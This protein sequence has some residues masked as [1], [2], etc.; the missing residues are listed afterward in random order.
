MKNSN[1]LI[2]LTDYRHSLYSTVKYGNASDNGIDLNRLENHIGSHGFKIRILNF[3][4]LDFT[5][6]NFTDKY[7]IYQS[8]EDHNAFYKSYIEDIIYAINLQGGII[9]PSFKY[10]KAHHNK[11][12]MELLRDITKIEGVEHSHSKKYG[13]LEEFLSDSNRI[14]FPVVIKSAAGTMS[15]TV[16]KAE[17]FNDAIKAIKFLSRTFNVKEALK[18]ILKKVIRNHYTPK[19]NYRNKFIVQPLIEGLDG[20]FK[21]LIFEGPKIFL[22]KRSLKRN[23]FRASG[24]GLISY[25]YDLDSELLDTCMKIYNSFNTPFISID[26]AKKNEEYFLIEFQFIMFGTTVLEKSK[27]FFTKNNGQWVKE[28][29]NNLILEE[30]YADSIIKFINDKIN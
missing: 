11:V 23:D 1:E 29:S 30:I 22:V 8:S 26:L 27:W 4:E 18:S 6:E 13:T 20:D 9:I 12:F 17:N 14:E 25:D 16:R 19:S 5:T 24:S 2:I 10:L 7:I 21:V 3:F 15:K 28:I